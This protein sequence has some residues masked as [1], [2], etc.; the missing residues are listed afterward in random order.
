[1]LSRYEA[2]I[3][4]M[5]DLPMPPFTLMKYRL[6]NIL[7]RDGNVFALVDILNAPL[8]HRI[9]DC[10]FDL[11]L[12]TVQEP[13]PVHCTLVLAIEPPVNEMRHTAAS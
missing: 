1:M 11:L 13:L 3:T 8:A 7:A 12:V 6:G 5:H 9:G 10:L 4:R 2:I